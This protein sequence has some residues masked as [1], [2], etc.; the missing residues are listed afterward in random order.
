MMSYQKKLMLTASIVILLTG[1]QVSCAAQECCTELTARLQA[2]L[3][4][5]SNETPSDVITAFMQKSCCGKSYEQESLLVRNVLDRWQGA[6]NISV[7]EL[8]TISR[9]PDVLSP[10]NGSKLI[11]DG[12]ISRNMGSE[13]VILIPDLL[14][15]LPG[16][17][18]QPYIQALLAAISDGKVNKRDRLEAIRAVGNMI[19]VYPNADGFESLSGLYRRQPKDDCLAMDL[20]VAAW[21]MGIKLAPEDAGLM[22]DSLASDWSFWL[23]KLDGA[24]VVMGKESAAKFIQLQEKNRKEHNLAPTPIKEHIKLNYT[25]LRLPVAISVWTNDK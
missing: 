18:S 4:G 5:K 3:N 21:K 2:A 23:W 14:D 10:Q 13:W 11:L 12:L 22:L 24:E 19:A 20:V 9:L 25:T 7:E 16:D 6:K 15:N 8:N 17:Q 1:M